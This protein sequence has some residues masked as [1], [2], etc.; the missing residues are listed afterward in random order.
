MGQNFPSG[1]VGHR[2]NF[3]VA[4][5]DQV[6]IVDLD[7]ARHL[8]AVA[9]SCRSAVE[10]GLDMYRCT[11][12][13]ASEDTDRLEAEKDTVYLDTAYIVSP[14]PERPEEAKA[15]ARAVG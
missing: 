3:G 6:D 11:P 13:A 15:P 9:S 14:A 2:Q 5:V 10:I 4:L 1:P 12:M 7:I 8:V